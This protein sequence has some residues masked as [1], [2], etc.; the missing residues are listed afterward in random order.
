METSSSVS[1]QKSPDH[2][3]SNKTEIRKWKEVQIQ[4]SEN[5]VMSVTGITSESNTELPL[6]NSVATVQTEVN[7]SL[8]SAPD[9]SL[10]SESCTVIKDLSRNNSIHPDAKNKNISVNIAD[11]MAKQS[12]LNTSK[13]FEPS[14][15]QGNKG[16]NRP[17]TNSKISN[18]CLSSNT[19]IQQPP[20]VDVKHLKLQEST[21][22][23]IGKVDSYPIKECTTREAPKMAIVA[24]TKSVGS[25]MVTKKHSNSPIGYKTL[26][27]P[28]KSWNPSISRASFLPSKSHLYSQSSPKKEQSSHFCEANV[29]ENSGNKVLPLSK[30]PR[31][32]KARNTP[33]YLGN[34]ASGVKPIFQV[35][36]TESV[37]NVPVKQET[38]SAALGSPKLANAKIMK[39]DPKTL[40]PVVSSSLR[41]T[42]PPAL[43]VMSTSAVLKRE[44]PLHGNPAR[45]LPTANKI[46]SSNIS[47]NAGLTTTRTTSSS[48]NTN[49]IIPNLPSTAAHQLYGNLPA[50]PG[51]SHPPPLIRSVSPHL[52]SAYHPLNMLY[53]PHQHNR[54]HSQVTNTLTTPAVQRIPATNSQQKTFSTNNNSIT[55]NNNIIQPKV[56]SSH[57]CHYST[58][59]QSS[60]ISSPKLPKVELSSDVSMNGERRKC[61]LNLNSNIESVDQTEHSADSE[62]RRESTNLTGN[63]KKQE[64]KEVEKNKLCDVSSGH[65]VSVNC[66]QNFPVCIK[67]A[68][69]QNLKKKE[70]FHVESFTLEKKNR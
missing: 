47:L 43:P 46:T 45:E 16:G 38:L 17:E 51:V 32:F 30:P 41:C 9:S 52:T 10:P 57:M 42:T 37:H 21:K 25:P 59:K 69:R 40:G 1:L 61:E 33:R 19:L 11:P 5:G 7:F 60:E 31:F 35:S 50:F 8:D 12:K 22:C 13:T 56:S 67:G 48:L 53:N 27:T 70:N 15:C 3:S 58:S 24:P 6:S 55:L 2:N 26:K 49:S 54:M 44:F 20:S 23:I 68:V 36:P 66:D 29:T 64:S 39:I 62:I 34:P 18:T 65:N 14:G 4:I 28:P 63:E